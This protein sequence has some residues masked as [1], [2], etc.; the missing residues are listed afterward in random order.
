MN[1]RVLAAVGDLF[2]AS[3]IRGTAQHLNVSVEFSRSA[4]SLFD[5]AK[6]E[7][8]SL[9]I[10]NLESEAADPLGLAARLKQDEQLRAVPLVGFLSHV[11]TDLQQSA[12]AAGVDH[13]LPR[14]AFTNRLADIL[15]GNL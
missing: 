11:R 5:A 4:D 15:L 12:R 7:V 8:P 6:L 2:F 9:I 10:L 3:K 14:S 13:V 1:R